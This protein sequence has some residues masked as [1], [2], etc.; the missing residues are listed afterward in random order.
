MWQLPDAGTAGRYLVAA[1]GAKSFE[2][3][4]RVT[5]GVIELARRA[6][7]QA[8]GPARSHVATTAGTVSLARL[9]SAALSATLYLRGFF[10]SA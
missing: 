3:V 1:K 6:P 10:P 2:D 8:T 5:V 4:L 9:I 7:R